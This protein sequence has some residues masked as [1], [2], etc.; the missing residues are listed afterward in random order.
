MGCGAVRFMDCRIAAVQRV[1]KRHSYAGKSADQACQRLDFSGLSGD[2]V[3]D[4]GFGLIQ[5]VKQTRIGSFFA[6][7]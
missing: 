1:V 2:I 6:L 7:T 4:G 5:K 3:C